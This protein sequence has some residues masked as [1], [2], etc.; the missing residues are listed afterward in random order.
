[1]HLLVDRSPSMSA[2]VIHEGV[3]L[4]RRIDLAWEAAIALAL[5]LEGISGVNPAVTAFPGQHGESDSVFRV[6]GHGARVRQRAGYFGCGTEGGTPLAESLWYAAS[7]LIGCRE[8]RKIILALTD[9][10]PDDEAAARD[11]LSRCGASGVEVVGIGLGIEVD[12]L[13]ERSITILQMA[14]LR[15]RL[16]ELSRDLLIAA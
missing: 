10:E 9:G 14:E 6:L 3:T 11:I 4:G 2:P 7:Q 15:S 16:F 1:V 5:A 13:F 8:P 12:H